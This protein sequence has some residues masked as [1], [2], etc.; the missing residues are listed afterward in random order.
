MSAPPLLRLVG[1][2]KTFE[3]GE[4]PVTALDGIDLEIAQ[5]E[6]IAI[7]GQSG[8]GKSTLMNVLGCLDRPS[9]GSYQVRGVDV[10]QL[11][12][13]EL[14]ALR[15]DTFGF[16][17]QR[18]NLLPALTAV[19][20]VEL[21]AIYAGRSLNERAARARSLLVRLGLGDRFD[22]RPTQLSGGQQQRVSIARALMNGA[23]VVLADEPTGALDSKS[24]LEVLE[25]LQQLHRQGHTIVLITHDMQ[26]AER[27]HRVVELFD[28][29]VV[30]DRRLVGAAAARSPAL[31]SEIQAFAPGVLADVREAARMAYRSLCTNWFRSLLT[32]LGVVIGVAAVVTMM[33]IGNGS[34]AA[35]ME[36][37]DS[38][39]TNL[40]L[41]FPG[42][43]G[44][45]PSGDTLATL[46]PDDARSVAALPGVQTVSP[47]RRDR[48]TLRF[49]NLD[50]QTTVTGAWPGYMKI[51]NWQIAAGEFF[52]EE[53][54]KRA[55][56]V[57]VLGNTVK[58]NLFGRAD[59][60][61]KFVLIGNVPFEVI[62]VLAEKGANAFGSDM[63]DTAIVPL[64]TG[65]VR[66]FGHKFVSMIN[67]KL[68]G[69]D[70]GGGV[71]A[72]LTA[73]LT[74]RHRLVDFQVRSTSELAA[75]ASETQDTF[76]YM[77][78]AVAAISLLVGGIGVMNI[79]LVNV[80]E[81]TREIGVRMATGARAAN[82]LLQFN[83]EA[84]VIC[85]VGGLVGV[86]LGLGSAALIHVFGTPVSYTLVP[87]VLA[88]SCA[89][90]TGL[91][92]GYLPA[93][94]AAHL[95]PV[96]ALASE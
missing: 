68:A 11:D 75:M 32:L 70:P 62:G 46:T 20:N 37:I 59:P 24:G 15:R 83:T 7:V 39:G 91:L 17:F 81:R 16:V 1:V 10:G 42:A 61:G 89:F 88:F 3:R 38:L 2:N 48:K 60:V 74:G 57:V 54:V 49:G 50:Y 87:V 96:I 58:E 72:A 73:L 52:N 84:L 65:F 45:R 26:I 86:A 31:G 28:G 12:P 76:T 93:R 8:S 82:I 92:F 22:H 69:T 56:A 21:P 23:E 47:E 5:G 80:T 40:L 14:A 77:L 64:E 67:V 19:E 6:F 85:G 63:D 25:L 51:Q 41:V 4:M 27:A 33:A 35:V 43:P 29:R 55:A 9:A 90:I 34:K 79:M 13:D 36:R 44:Q 94:K 95:D 30:A 18:Y 53:D 78:A 66:L 71:E